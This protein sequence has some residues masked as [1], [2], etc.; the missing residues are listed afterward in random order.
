M[1][2]PVRFGRYSSGTE[3]LTFM[4]KSSETAGKIEAALA[5]FRAQPAELEFPIDPEFR[6]DP[7]HLDPVEMYWRCEE[8]MRRGARPRKQDWD[9]V[10]PE[11][12]L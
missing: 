12:V 8:L 4:R 2:L 11:F 3:H 9:G 7:P 6:S 5:A 1:L 10:V